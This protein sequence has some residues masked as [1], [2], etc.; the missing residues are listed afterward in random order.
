M[1]LI[2]S[3]VVGSFLF[4][5]TN[6]TP[7]QHSDEAA[8][9]R[10]ADVYIHL[11]LREHQSTEIEQMLP[12]SGNGAALDS[13]LMANRMTKEE[14]RKSVFLTLKDPESSKKFFE[15]VT[16]KLDSRKTPLS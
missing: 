2:A 10:V 12:S 9:A 15:V 11:L 7:A 5:A 13:V 8:I 6:C 14:F 4:V 16:E 3:S 1:K